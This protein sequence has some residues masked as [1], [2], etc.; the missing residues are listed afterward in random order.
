[1]NAPPETTS[2]LAV[3]LFYDLA[4]AA[5]IENSPARLHDLP[6]EAVNAIRVWAVQ[7]EVAVDNVEDQGRIVSF[8]DRAV[9]CFAFKERTGY[10]GVVCVTEDGTFIGEDSS[11]TR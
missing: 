11:I 3:R 1:M 8:G 7:R 4:H 6:R 9:F 5:R 2:N 10:S